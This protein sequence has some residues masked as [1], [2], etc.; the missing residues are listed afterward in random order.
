MPSCI[1]GASWACRDGARRIVA[2]RGR[3]RGSRAGRV[4]RYER[5]RAPSRNTR[6]MAELASSTPTASTDGTMRTTIPSQQS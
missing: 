4:A 5:G 3:A 1:C 6:T 2:R